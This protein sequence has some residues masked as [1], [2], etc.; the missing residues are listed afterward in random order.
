MSLQ[1]AMHFLGQFW[2]DPFGGRDLLD[3]RFSQAIDR[4]E[5]S[6]EQIFSVLAHA[7]AIVEN[8]FVDP[9]LEQQ[10]VISICEAMRLVADSLKQ[11]ECS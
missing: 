2:A 8:T 11:V 6:Q 4:T 5:F 7:R 9:F 3:A 10:L 1:K